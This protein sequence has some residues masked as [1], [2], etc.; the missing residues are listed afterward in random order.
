MALTTMVSDERDATVR[1][2]AS[3]S[4]SLTGEVG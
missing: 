4:P 2:D 1:E 3:R